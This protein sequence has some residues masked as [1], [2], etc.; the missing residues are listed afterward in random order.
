[1]YILYET[2]DTLI[3][4]LLHSD[5]L[6]FVD[7]QTDRSKVQAPKQ[8]YL[9]RKNKWASYHHPN[10]LSRIDPVIRVLTDEDIFIYF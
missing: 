7:R 8:H 9:G 5:I 3:E 4:D 1:M 2:L 6:S 10:Y